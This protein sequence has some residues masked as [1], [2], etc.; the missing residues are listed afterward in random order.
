MVDFDHVLSRARRD[1]VLRIFYSV[2]PAELG[3]GL[4]AQGLTP[5]LAG[6]PAELAAALA[7]LRQRG[8]IE[9]IGHAAGSGPAIDRLTADGV[10]AVESAPDADPTRV[11]GLR[12]LRLRV[13]QAL[14]W[15]GE[16][17]LAEALIAAA[18]AEDADLDLTA[19]SLHRACTY[20]AARGL[21]EPVDAPSGPRLWRILPDGI[22][23]L[24]G[25]GDGIPGVARPLAW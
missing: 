5:D 3:A 24:E 22:D 1:A 4:V 9:H 23:Y 8:H 19:P 25:T 14:T 12:M 10:D 11:R 16:R 13:L 7:Y 17:P 21:V 15:G 6:T 2:W 20:L 18:L